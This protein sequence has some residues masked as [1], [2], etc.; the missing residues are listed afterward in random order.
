[1]KKTDLKITRKT[2]MAEIVERYPELG[3]VLTEDYGF[4]C[5]GCFAA[6]MENLEQGAMVHGMTKKEIDELVKTLNGLIK[7]IKKSKVKKK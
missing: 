4:H 7:D 6:E 1:M 5:I 3:E 2:L